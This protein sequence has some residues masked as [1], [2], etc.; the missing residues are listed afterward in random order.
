M[1]GRTLLI[2]FGAF[3]DTLLYG[4]TLTLKFPNMCYFLKCDVLWMICDVWFAMWPTDQLT[5]KTIK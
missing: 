3:E 2:K 5:N 4:T 1:G